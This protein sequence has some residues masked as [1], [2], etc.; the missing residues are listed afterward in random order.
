MLPI[1]AQEESDFCEGSPG[2]GCVG[3]RCLSRARGAHFLSN[4]R[5]C[6]T[7]VHAVRASQTP[8]R[9]V[10]AIIGRFSRCHTGS[11][12]APLSDKMARSSGN[13]QAEKRMAVLIGVVVVLGDTTNGARKCTGSTELR[14][15]SQDT[16]FDLTRQ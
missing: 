15:V 10:M 16:P 13:H 6:R 5:A 14:G 1:D 3:W 4:A 8:E 12:N 2:S 11:S 7:D 9:D